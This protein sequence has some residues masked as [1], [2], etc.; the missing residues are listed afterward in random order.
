MKPSNSKER[1]RERKQRQ[2]MSRPQHTTPEW[3]KGDGPIPVTPPCNAPEDVT[4]H[5]KGSNIGPTGADVIPTHASGEGHNLIAGRTKGRTPEERGYPSGQVDV[6]IGPQGQKLWRLN[7]YYDM[8]N[9]ILT[10]NA[11]KDSFNPRWA[12]SVT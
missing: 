8:P 9:R 10:F 12:D 2:R 1:T 11:S 4:P 3:A 6:R 7:G 5:T